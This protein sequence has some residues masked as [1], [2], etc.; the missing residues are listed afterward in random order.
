VRRAGTGRALVLASGISGFGDIFIADC[1]LAIARET[2]LE[3]RNPKLGSQWWD[4][5]LGFSS[6]DFRI[7]IF[8]FQPLR[9]NRQ[10][11]IGNHRQL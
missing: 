10:S 11:S 5:E 9:I 6:F 1:R 4:F 3:N 8:E 2:K 7:S